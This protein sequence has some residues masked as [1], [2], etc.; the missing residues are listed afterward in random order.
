MFLLAFTW[1]IHVK[2]VTRTFWADF[3]GHPYRSN[4]TEI[5]LDA[6]LPTSLQGSRWLTGESSNKAVTNMRWVRLPPRQYSKV[7]LGNANN[8]QKQK[9]LPAA[10][11]FPYQN[12]LPTSENREKVVLNR[13]LI[14]FTYSWLFARKVCW[15]PVQ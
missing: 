4:G 12:E 3:F 8:W 14:L 2:S 10:I 7:R 1:N 9:N 11:P 6:A 15:R 5:N 13:F